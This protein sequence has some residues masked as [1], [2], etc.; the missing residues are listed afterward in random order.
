M[1]VS[2]GIAIGWA[3]ESTVP[4]EATGCILGISAG[5]FF[6]IALS[7]LV[8]E[9]MPGGKRSPFHCGAAFFGAGIMYMALTLMY[10]EEAHDH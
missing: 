4:S 9:A 1:N 8:P 6:M 5:T 7:D 2:V 10:S 3:L